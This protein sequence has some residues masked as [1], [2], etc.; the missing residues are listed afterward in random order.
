MYR[1]IPRAGCDTVTESMHAFR[2]RLAWVVCGW[3][4]CQMAGV[5]AG[6]VLMWRVTAA[7]DDRECECPVTPGQACPMHHNGNGKDHDGKRDDTTC[8][9]RNALPPADAALFAHGGFGILPGPIAVARV[10]D[11]G[12]IV[13]TAAPSAVLRVYRPESPPPRS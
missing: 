13:A 5:F 6:P 2:R 8:K 11:P 4:A 7:H 3:L 1:V 9:L 10:L 12:A